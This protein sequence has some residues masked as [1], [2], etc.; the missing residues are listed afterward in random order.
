LA[1]GG[2]GAR[3]L[4]APEVTDIWF[5]SHLSLAEI[6]RRLGLLDVTEDAE[7]Y[8]AWVIGGLGDV[9]LDITRTHTRPA[10]MVDTRVF[11]LDGK[12]TEPLL[13]E[14]VERLRAF[15]PGPIRCGRWEYRS[16]NDF[17]LVV[18]REFGPTGDGAPSNQAAPDRDGT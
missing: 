8:W 7:N 3:R 15:V 17:D 10:G 13:A 14:L 18:V 1:F 2:G 4:M 12:F 9:R 11:L 16:G 5:H 6:A